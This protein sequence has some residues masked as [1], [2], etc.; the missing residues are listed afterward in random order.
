MPLKLATA[1][2]VAADKEAARLS[3]DAG[4]SR[5]LAFVAPDP[6]PAD[7]AIAVTV[8]PGTPSA[9]GPLVTQAAQS[10]EFRTYAPLR[11]E[12]HGCSWYGEECPPLTPFYIEFNNPLDVDA[13]QE[14][15]LRIEPALPGATVDVAGNTIS[16]RGATAGR[17]TYTV[18]VDAAIQD[19]FGQTLGKEA[20]LDFKVGSAEP[21]LIGPQGDFVTLDPASKKPA[22]TVYSV[23][24]K[25][26]KVRAYQVQ[27]SDW[28]AYRTFLQEYYYQADA[29]E[30]PGRLAMDKTIPLEAAPD[31]LLETGIDLGAALEGGLGHLV[32][33]VEPEPHPSGKDSYY[34][35]IRAWVQVTQIGLD[36]FSDAGQAVAWA[37]ALKDGAPLAEVAIESRCRQAGSRHRRRRNGPL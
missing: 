33:I 31:V 8:G 18:T 13:Y 9:E 35:M 11:I 21:S 6:L 36:A 7:A 15:M 30:P 27:P 29:P 32:V 10:Y 19:T 37:T 23:N 17:T 1:G 5:W 14:A 16:I 24:Y 3:K 25:R 2:Q 34:P 28:V 4:E 20:V 26:L 22:L 12:R